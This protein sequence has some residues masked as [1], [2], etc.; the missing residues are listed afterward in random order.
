[1]KTGPGRIVGIGSIMAY[2]K[3]NRMRCR[4]NYRMRNPIECRMENRD[5]EGQLTVVACI[6]MSLVILAV[7]CYATVR[8]DIEAANPEREPPLGP[9]FEDARTAFLGILQQK[10]SGSDMTVYEVFNESCGMVTTAE[11][12]YGFV[13]SAEITNITEISPGEYDVSL[14]VSLS[15]HYGHASSVESVV[16]KR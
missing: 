7:A 10:Y 3:G 15:A 14:T 9:E 8:I 5:E 4:M 12:R 16:L 1:M 6:V 13:F 2:H 11:A